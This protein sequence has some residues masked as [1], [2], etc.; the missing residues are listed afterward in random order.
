MFVSGGSIKAATRKSAEKNNSRSVERYDTW[1]DSWVTMP[2]LL[3][4][5]DR[6]SSCCAGQILFVFCGVRVVDDTSLSSIEQLDLAKTELGWTLIELPV[7]P[8]RMSLGAA[9]LDDNYIL[10]LGGKNRGYSITQLNDVWV[11][12]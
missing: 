5:R 8:A 4:G 1:T 10:I 2:D 3:E 6:H 9:T 7:L 11:Y 12:C